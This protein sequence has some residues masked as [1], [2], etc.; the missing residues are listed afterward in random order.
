LLIISDVER[1]VQPEETPQR[2]SVFASLRAKGRIISR[3]GFRF[4]VP[5]ATVYLCEYFINQGLL[6]L[7]Y[8]KDIWL[9][10]HS[11]YRWLQVDYQLGVFLSRSS[12]NFYPIHS[13]W[14]LAFLQ[15][16]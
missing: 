11:Q 1:L 10:H 16:K 3:I 14:L 7:I 4:I 6:E 2:R 12:V 5:L 8:F 13:I 15:V 9:N